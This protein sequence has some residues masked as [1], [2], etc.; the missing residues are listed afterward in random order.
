MN[1]SYFLAVLCLWHIMWL[2]GSECRTCT[3]ALSVLSRHRMPMNTPKTLWSETVVSCEL[4]C[5]YLYLAKFSPL[6][7][8][9]CVVLVFS[10]KTCYL[11]DWVEFYNKSSIVFW[12]GTQTEFQQCL[13]MH[14]P[15]YILFVQSKVTV[16]TQSKKGAA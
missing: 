1:P 11:S 8:F 13:N 12:L 4:Q 2:Y 6:C 16:G 14:L 15:F 7:V 5:F 3:L 10:F 9:G